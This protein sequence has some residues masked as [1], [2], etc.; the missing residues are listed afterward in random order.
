MKLALH[1]ITYAGL[2]YEGG[3]L[4]IEQVIARAKQF[5]YNAVEVFAARP[6]CSP[7]DFDTNQAEKLR[8]YAEAQGIE[9]CTVAGY[10][11]LPR[12]T[13]LDRE[14][15]LVFARE[16]FRLA[17]D[18]GAPAVRVYAGGE[19]MH[20]GASAWQ[21][22]DWC[23]EAIK[24][25]VPLAETYNIDI[26]LEWHTGVVQSTD[27]LLDMIE[28]V[29]SE[30]I[31]VLLDPPHLSLRGESASEAVSKVGPLLVHAHI[32]DFT[33]G[34]PVLSSEAVPE[35]AFRETM[36]ANHVPLGEGMVEIEPFVRACKKIGYQG[37]LAFEVCTPFH[38]HHRM[39]TLDDVD[40]LVQQA[41]EYMKT[42]L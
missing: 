37:E 38:V 4:T 7:F 12:T 35:L 40:R 18:L 25:L 42:M 17:R 2:F 11:D 32:S 22:W 5:G 14:K 3:S 6:V 31:K 30:R 1:G 41:S 13:P 21:Q 9:F 24:E 8:R 39:P 34:S 36:P 16:T 20:P 10:I 33:R 27:A 19:H 15:E 29:G 26:A 23:V 28:Q